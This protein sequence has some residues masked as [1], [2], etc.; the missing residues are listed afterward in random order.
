MNADNF[1]EPVVLLVVL[2]NFD[3]SYTLEKSSRETLYHLYTFFL[4]FACHFPCSR[5]FE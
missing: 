2:V 5:R 4:F 3:I 1:L